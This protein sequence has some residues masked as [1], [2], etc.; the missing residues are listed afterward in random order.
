MEIERNKKNE[1]YKKKMKKKYIK[2][3]KTNK[4]NCKEKGI[5]VVK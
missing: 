3:N 1:T 4:E 5:S 2:R